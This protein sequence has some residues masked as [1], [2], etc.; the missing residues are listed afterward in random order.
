MSVWP[1]LGRR[2]MRLLGGPGVVGVLLLLGAAAIAWGLR[3]SLAQA[4]Q[5]LLRQYVSRLDGAPLA[6]P[7]PPPRDPRDA[8]RDSWPAADELGKV[9]ARLA[10]LAPK[11][12]K[13]TPGV[14][15]FQLSAPTR[16]ALPPGLLR[17]RVGMQFNARYAQTRA[18][19][20]EVLNTVPNAALDTLLIEPGPPRDSVLRCRLVWSLYFREPA[21]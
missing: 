19:L 2:V 20:A 18:L 3:P 1:G 15:G 14:R 9:L 5:A 10:T 21:P 4:Q 16:E 17:V 6:P 11:P 7:A 8:V 13:G 12:A